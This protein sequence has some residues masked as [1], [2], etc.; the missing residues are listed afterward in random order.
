MVASQE[1]LLLIRVGRSEGREQH[2]QAQLNLGMSSRESAQAPLLSR[3]EDRLLARS[4]SGLS[5]TAQWQE[6][7]LVAVQPGSVVL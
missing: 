7:K 6:C 5:V 4:G 2:P 3:H 1:H